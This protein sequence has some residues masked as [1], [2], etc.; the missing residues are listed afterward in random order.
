MMKR[1]LPAA[2]GIL[3]LTVWVPPSWGMGA[4]VVFKPSSGN[5]S[6]RFTIEG[7]MFHPNEKVII[8]W[9]P[10]SARL[11]EVQADAQGNLTVEVQVPS[12]A[13]PGPNLVILAG[14]QGSGVAQEF[15]VG[16]PAQEPE[17]E[18]DPENEEGADGL[19]PWVYGGGGIAVGLILGMVVFRR[20]TA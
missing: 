9:R 18:E 11:A 13:H 16:G 4:N 7:T 10:S 8:N 20:K 15:T 12:D 14:D 6:D 19:E 5:P 17:T 1:I 2:V 3:I